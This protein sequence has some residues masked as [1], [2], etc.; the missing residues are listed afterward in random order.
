MILGQNGV[1]FSILLLP[2]V[3]LIL[4]TCVAMG[5]GSHKKENQISRLVKTEKQ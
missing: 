4:I 5:G 3:K 2:S 1:K